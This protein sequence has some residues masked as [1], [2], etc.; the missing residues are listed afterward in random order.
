VEVPGHQLAA[1]TDN[2]DDDPITNAQSAPAVSA[3]V[4]QAAAAAREIAA[5]A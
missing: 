1:R 5:G 3:G 4:L 2:S